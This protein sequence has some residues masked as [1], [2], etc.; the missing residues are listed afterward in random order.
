MAAAS[1][2]ITRVSL[3]VRNPGVTR[4]MILGFLNS[5]NLAIADQVLLPDLSDGEDSVETVTGEYLTQLPANFH[6]N[7]FL[8]QADG[9]PIK[10]FHSFKLMMVQVNELS[11]DTGTINS[12]S[13]LGG[14]LVYQMV[15]AEETTIVLKYY[16]K[17]ATLT[18]SALVYPEGADDSQS[19]E[20][21]LVQYCA[22]KCSEYVEDGIDGQKV[23]T[24]YHKQMYQEELQNVKHFSSRHSGPEAEMP[25][26]SYKS[27]FV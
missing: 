11:I 8:C 17:P 13:I 20:E 16:R 5:G 15:P 12:C 24:A 9:Q 7:I 23:N 19:F 26:S 22:W 10:L 4:D 1:D 18:D 27:L 25:N 3:I 21:A 2:I 14:N 6:R